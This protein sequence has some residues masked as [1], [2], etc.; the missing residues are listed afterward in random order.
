MHRWKQRPS[1]TW[2][3]RHLLAWVLIGFL[4]GSGGLAQKDGDD[5][6]DDERDVQDFSLS[7]SPT[8]ASV[9]QGS[10]RDYTVELSFISGDGF[11]DEI[12]LT[13]SGLGTGLTST[14]LGSVSS[15]DLSSPFTITAANGA[16]LGSHHFTVTGSAAN[17]LTRTA[18]G[19]VTVTAR[20]PTSLSIT[21]AP[22]ADVAIGECYTIRAGNA[23]NMTLDLQYRKDGGATQTI[24]GSPALN[25]SGL[26]SACPTLASQVGNYVFTAYR[27]TQ[28][29]DWISSNEG[30]IVV[31]ARDFE[32]SVSPDHRTVYRGSTG[33]Q[34]VHVTAINGFSSA[35]SLS[36][37]GLPSGASASLSRPS[38]TPTGTS[39]L[40]L[41]VGS[42]V[43]PG[44][45]TYTVTGTGGGQTRTDTG[46]LVVPSFEVSV[47]PDP[48][49]VDRGLS[50]TYAVT[51][52]P[53]DGFSM[54][55]TLSVTG[56]GSGLTGSFSPNPVT[57]QGTVT[58][59]LTI[60]TSCSASRGRDSFDVT[61]TGG[62]YTDID[63]AA[64]VVQGFSVSN[65]P[66][67]QNLQRPGSVDY[68]VDVDRDPGFLA[69]VQ[70]SV[71]GLPMGVTG[72]F[73]PNPARSESTLTLDATSNAPLGRHTFTVT[74]TAHGCTDDDS[75]DV[76]IVDPPPDPE[77]ELSM[78]PESG[79]VD[80]GSSRTYTV[81]VDPETG[82]TS[83]VDLSVSG[84]RSG[85]T[86][87]FSTDPVTPSDWTST[88]TVTAVSCSVSTLAD[89]FTVTGTGGGHTDSDSDEVVP[90]TFS[91]S[92]STE[93]E[94]LERGASVQYMVTVSP[95][96]G[97]AA[98]VALSVSGLPSGVTG[99]F[100]PTSTRST[101]ILTLSATPDATLG[102]DTFT[103]T[104]TAHGCPVSTTDEVNVIDSDTPG[105]ELSM[106][107]ESGTVEWGTSRTY[108]V[109]VSPD[110]SFTSGV[111]LSV[112]GLEP[113]LS[114]SFSR[115]PVTSSDWTSTLTIT[116]SCNAS[117]G[118]DDFT[119]TGTG[120]GLTAT[121]PGIAAVAG[122]E[123]SMAPAS[124][125]LTPGASAP[126]TITIVADAGFASAVTLSG[127]GLPSGV[128]G[129]FSPISTPSA[130]VL[131]LTA[132]SS[133]PPGTST[134]T[135]TGTANGCPVSSSVPIT[136]TG[137]GFGVEMTPESATLRQGARVEY[138]V[139]VAPETG[140][141]SDVTLSVAALPAG[142]TG[143]FS[144]NPV[145]A[146]SATP[147]TSTLTL[148]ADL[149][150]P[151]GPADFTV[152][153]TSGDLSVSDTVTV[154][155]SGPIC[156]ITR[157]PGSVSVAPGTS[158]TL[159]VSVGLTTAFSFATSFD[160]TV[161]GLP[162]GVTG[163]FAPAQVTTNAP[164]SMLTLTA[165]PSAAAVSGEFNI[166][167]SGPS[168]SCAA[169]AMIQVGSSGFSLSADPLMVSVAPGAS[170]ASLVTVA[171]VGAFSAPVALA[172]SGL[173]AEVMG[174]FDPSSVTPTT[175]HPAPTSTLT[176][177]AGASAIPGT[178]PF[179]LSGTAGALT[180]EILA[181]AVVT[182]PEPTGSF[183]LS[184][185]PGSRDVTKGDRGGFRVTV[186]RTDGF[187]APVTLSVSG[188]SNKNTP[189]FSVNPVPE[190]TA[191]SR[192]T[193]VVGNNARIG[194]DE[195]TLTGTAGTRTQ[196]VTATVDVEAPG[197]QDFT[198]EVSPKHRLIDPGS[199][200]T[201]AVSVPP[202][203]G[204]SAPV[205]LSVRDLAP[206]FTSQ[207]TDSSISI[208]GR[209]KLTITA[210]DPAPP[211]EETFVIQGIAEFSGG[212]GTT[213]VRRATAAVA[214][215]PSPDFT[216]S[217]D[218][219]TSRTIARNQSLA[220]NL[221]VTR[222][223][224]LT[225]PIAL[226]V[227]GLE[228]D[229][230]LTP[231]FS[232]DSLQGDGEPSS[233][234]T[235]AAGSNAVAGTDD[236]VIVAKSEDGSL[237]RTASQSV[238]VT[239]PDFSLEVLPWSKNVARA[240]PANQITGEDG[241]CSRPENANP[242]KAVACARTFMVKVHPEPLPDQRVGSV[243]LTLSSL[244]PGLSG[245]FSDSTVT[246]T[247]TNPQSST[248]TIKADSTATLGY[249]QFTITGTGQYTD[250][251]NTAVTLTRTTTARVEVYIGRDCRCAD[252]WSGNPQETNP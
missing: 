38:V 27:N 131:T 2:W 127:A 124:V 96:S 173:P 68:T 112:T 63:S 98:S 7:V 204:L 65:S 156:E 184:V 147:W 247:G 95:Q 235:I 158:Q 87:S 252:P 46:Y 154:V 155:V 51:L 119:V 232:D 133:A 237:I 251:N 203:R 30:L 191:S 176:L 193:I 230:G 40:T 35:V 201:Y 37:S 44:R 75:D 169:T 108:T 13:I 223:G 97:F 182:E 189:S 194:D 73:D 109:T 102:R 49:N 126:H 9:V 160:L 18:S 134:F 149:D 179:T 250:A 56:L 210:P 135:L 209:T 199:S 8:S 225:S 5:D 170:Q 79:N 239:G 99:D 143:A 181:T 25:S 205:E 178:Y 105:F 130:S 121:E 57:P 220:Y 70:L 198:L 245:S 148:M 116:A 216:L 23:A 104:G 166:A 103:V 10:S 86:W 90:R 187:S 168:G 36:V 140:F 174:T 228:S 123:L 234:L 4:A 213:T 172:A 32:V 141:T 15:S 211:G 85:L 229:S 62:G 167:A 222:L 48:G 77:F 164:D 22:P 72:D 238:T 26:A 24:T 89:S 248:L 185:S 50:R 6:D 162:A 52:T 206:G 47:S 241:T 11:D 91:V 243:T 161:S 151:L 183:T 244:L 202:I 115:N 226:S 188:L 3:W 186:D 42:S 236:F 113:G 60:G 240:P 43:P 180:Q 146:N 233:V 111:E 152:T 69:S 110:S 165:G 100:N 92:T 93:N 117:A 17:G 163:T 219:P 212:I 59:T 74:G 139:P 145:N 214:E 218:P 88:L 150:A 31:P 118:P 196:S 249:H 171:A 142:V 33:T 71:S 78:T 136:I 34:T 55:V 129:S 84:L 94:D 221:N 14:S 215:V 28:S 138:A 12:N 61:G 106:I 224:S 1:G 246:L 54:P 207:F 107:P 82:F 208:G 227:I 137:A 144:P 58:S 64:V 29:S 16:T 231:T 120:G 81:T 67:A 157:E 153:G 125:T 192:L 242:T 66:E 76:I 83:D 101:S 114:G 20:Q 122:F 39:T 45:Y 190:S 80:R 159:D 132:D 200:R 41:N 175:T 177:T 53:I 19:T 128:T 217:V 197:N 21:P 195:F